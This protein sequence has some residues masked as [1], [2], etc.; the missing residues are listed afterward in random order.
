MTR[1]R[2]DARPANRLLA[3]LPQDAFEQCRPHLT[4]IA[5]RARQVLQKQDAR[6]H[7]V[8]FPNG[9]IISMATVLSDGAVVE[10][11]TIGSEGMVGIEAFFSGRSVSPCE[12]MVQVPMLHDS[13]ERMRISDFRRA[14]DQS[15]VLHAAVA[16]F[17]QVLYARITRLTACNVRHDLNE[18]CA[19]WLLM[20]HD[21]MEG[22]DFHLS[23]EFLAVMLGVRRQTVSL[24][25]GAFRR[26]GFIRYVQG[27]IAVVDRKGLEAAACECYESIS[28]LYH[29]LRRERG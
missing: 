16:Q 27:R 17:A 22:K 21:Q 15:E 10:A 29:S 5:L 23:Q 25:A 3:R 19:R 28:G 7:Y 9:G 6:I 24:V 14:L 11:A 2:V 26:A 20:A 18:R 4:T 1:A 8:Y 12:T 13:A